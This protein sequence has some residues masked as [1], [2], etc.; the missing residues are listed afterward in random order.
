MRFTIEKLI[1]G[2][3][4]LARLPADEHG[5]GKSVF[6]PF[7]LDGEEVDAQIVEEKPGFARARIQTVLSASPDRVEPG[8]PYFLRCGGCQYQHGSYEHQIKAK[9][10]ILV[11]TL[12]RTAKLELPCELQVHPSAEWNYRNRTRLKVN[13]IPEFALGYYKFRSHELLQIERCPISSPLINRAITEIWDAGRR[14]EIPP[15]VREIELFA[16]SEDKQLLVE[17]YCDEVSG[18]AEAEKVAT[19]LKQE[20]VSACGIAVFRQ[21]PNQF[22]EPRNVAATGSA[23]IEYRAKL[24]SYRVSAGAF[25]QVNRFL[26]DELVTIVTEGSSGKLALDFYAGVGLFS[27]VLAKSF[28]Q[29]IAVESSQTSHGDLRHN[30]PQEVKAVLA[31]TEQYLGQAS[32]IRPDLVVVDPPRGGLGENV[33]R[34]LVKLDAPRTVYVSC[35]PSTL[36]RDLRMLVGSGYR[37]IGAHLIDLFPQTFHIESVFQLAR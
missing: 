2:G 8:C 31:T 19:Q 28:A 32:G 12:R 15:S 13:T 7:S 30:A 26:I 4:G 14:R 17:A 36:A 5:R 16:D 9:A 34:G 23:E 35:D 10:G 20:L 22:A 18:K 29:V 24:A 6:V 37:I 21:A 1:Y 3:D 27:A 11:E 25:F 33:V